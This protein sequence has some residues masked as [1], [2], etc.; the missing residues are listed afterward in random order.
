M[1]IGIDSVHASSVTV[2]VS[3]ACFDAA[4]SDELAIAEGGRIDQGRCELL[5]VERDLT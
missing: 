1:F 5:R 2:M 3:T 4:S